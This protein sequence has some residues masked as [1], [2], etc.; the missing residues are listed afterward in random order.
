MKISTIFPMMYGN[1]ENIRNEFPTN[2]TQKN[3]KVKQPSLSKYCGYRLDHYVF[4]PKAM[5][6]E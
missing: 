3:N 4:K 1:T 2:I 6:I 5:T